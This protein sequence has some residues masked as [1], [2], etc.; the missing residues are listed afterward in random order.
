MIKKSVLIIDKR[1]E[2]STKYK[3]LLEQIGV[4][5]VVA[6]EITT[7]IKFLT[8]YEPDLILVSDSLEGKL[9]ENCQKI[10]ILSSAMR[11]YIV[12]ISKSE[13]LQDKLDV[14]SMGADDFLSEPIDHEEFKARI[15][16]HLRMIFENNLNEKT[17]LPSSKVTFKI[18]R[19]TIVEKELFSALLI[20]IKYA[21]Y[22][23]EIYGA[24]AYEKMIQTLGAIINSTVDEKDFVGQFS[25]D[26]FLIITHPL[27][28][29]KISQY[30]V[31]AFDSISSKFYSEM[32]AQRGYI[33]T[34]GE[35]KE[36]KAIPLVSL[37]IGGISNEYRSYSTAGQAINSL[38]LLHDLAKSDNKS[39]YILERPKLGG[40][41]SIENKP[42]NNNILIIEPDEALLMLLSSTLELQGY[43]VTTLNSFEDFN[44]INFQNFALILIE[45]GD[46]EDY[47]GL[48]IC[49]LIKT[50]NPKIK[51]IVSNIYH[52]KEKILN[53]MADLYL[54]K[55]FELSNLFRFINDMVKEFNY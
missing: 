35:D 25:Q 21:N 4:Y 39:A 10:K 27:K 16:A 20:D 50:N 9:S 42:Y 2:L 23:K 55:P 38:I 5:T 40:N 51:V 15:N 44:E 8:R 33:I 34:S 12:A 11:P 1:I 17:L 18:F 54:P 46:K 47:K 48:E 37:S 52:D 32:D 49:K 29:E 28:A 30:L 24:L 31:A 13:H 22:Y 53:A 45:A 19:R 26:D 41:D 6:N 36:G 3:K 43:E 14:L 7:A